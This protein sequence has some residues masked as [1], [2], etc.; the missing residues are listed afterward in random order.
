MQLVDSPVHHLVDSLVDSPVRP[1]AAGSDNAILQQAGKVTVAELDWLQL[2]QL[3]AWKPVDV[4][5]GT[6]CIYNEE[7]LERLLRV[8]LHLATAHTTGMRPC[9]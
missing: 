3:T 2:D 5:V 8:V 1:L 7:L 6:D 4:I 9:G